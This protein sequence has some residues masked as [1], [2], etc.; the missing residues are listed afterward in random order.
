MEQAQRKVDEPHHIVIEI[1]PY[2]LASFAFIACYFCSNKRKRLKRDD[3]VHWNGRNNNYS[4]N[5]CECHTLRLFNEKSIS[6]YWGPINDTCNAKNELIPDFLSSNH[7]SHE[8]VTT[9]TLESINWAC[10]QTSFYGKRRGRIFNEYIESRLKPEIIGFLK[11]ICRNKYSWKTTALPPSFYELQ[12]RLRKREFIASTNGMCM[13]DVLAFTYVSVFISK[14]ITVENLKERLI[15]QTPNLLHW[16][17][18]MHDYLRTNLY[19]TMDETDGAK[20]LVVKKYLKTAGLDVAIPLLDRNMTSWLNNGTK[21][22]QKLALK[23]E[24]NVFCGVR[25]RPTGK[26][27]TQKVKRSEKCKINTVQNV[28]EGDKIP[29]SAINKNQLS[30]IFSKLQSYIQHGGESH[31]ELKFVLQGADSFSTTT[32]STTMCVDNNNNNNIR[33]A[34]VK[35]ILKKWNHVIPKTLNPIHYKMG[36]LKKDRKLKKQQ[37]V[38]NMIAWINHLLLQCQGK[39]SNGDRSNMN[40]VVPALKK[41]KLKNNKAKDVDD[42]VAVEFCCGSGHVGLALAALRRDITVVLIDCNPI[43]IA[44]AQSRAV[45]ANITNVQFLTM[46][47]RDFDVKNYPGI[48]IGF[49]LHACGPATDYALQKCLEAQAGYVFAPCCVGFIQNESDSARKL[50][51]SS[52]FRVDCG[53]QRDEFLLLSRIADHTSILSKQGSQAML[54]VNEDRNCLAK[55]HGYETHHTIMIPSTCT[56]KNNI[57]FGTIP[58]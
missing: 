10:N 13:A 47:I 31:N 46:D 23:C 36:Q 12:E 26:K 19:N 24:N 15:D 37:Q 49:A 20:G 7:C 4:K 32:T 14:A 3:V 41:Q 56:P 27:R 53:I 5:S 6:I 18:G 57:I 38:T 44:L 8:Q 42:I 39:S 21:Y 55:E 25:S 33:N 51:C 22:Q 34:L 11:N 54:L 40:V 30:I 16:Y 43:S 17:L 29:S 9:T 1:D 35:T 50:P 48:K 45:E 28:V 52:L 2:S 58:A